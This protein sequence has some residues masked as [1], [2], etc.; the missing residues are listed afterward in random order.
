MGMRP[1][2]QPGTIQRK[3]PSWL[4]CAVRKAECEGSEQIHGENPLC[5]RLHELECEWLIPSPEVL[6]V[7]RGR[8]I[9]VWLLFSRRESI[10]NLKEYME[11]NRVNGVWV[12]RVK[13]YKVE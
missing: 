4:V 3:C 5:G 8:D 10:I 12:W 2:K 6:G 11:K 1:W 9:F 13:I 7:A